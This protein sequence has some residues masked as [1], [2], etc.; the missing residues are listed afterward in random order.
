MNGEALFARFVAASTPRPSPKHDYHV[1]RAQWAL[2]A[3]LLAQPPR[4]NPALRALLLPRNGQGLHS[5]LAA[6]T[7][8]DDI[9]TFSCGVTF[10]D[11]A[12]KQDIEDVPPA[13][14]DLCR[15]SF[16]M[17][18]QGRVVGY[19]SQRGCFI[20]RARGP[21]DAEPA[22]ATPIVLLARL[23]VDRRA[24]GKGFGTALLRDAVSR[25]LEIGGRFGARALCVHALS[26]EVKRFY[27][28]RGF[29]PMPAIIDALGV[30]V[31][32]ED[33]R[34]VLADEGADPWPLQGA[35]A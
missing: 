14:D 10:L 16:A 32:F 26:E 2:F 30:M 4:D 13:T 22:P 25:A 6:L 8:S 15:R 11:A 12:L 1:G 33:V 29:R 5:A 23:A 35:V 7:Q 21:K 3:A 31:T 20:R 19:Y 28:V 17:T 18:A 9:R 24:H 34:K 27:L